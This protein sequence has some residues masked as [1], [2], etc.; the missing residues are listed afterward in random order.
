MIISNVTSYGYSLRTKAL[1]NTKFGLR[2][3][4]LLPLFEASVVFFFMSANVV[5]EGVLLIGL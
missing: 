4:T 1:Q 5:K 2:T 3:W